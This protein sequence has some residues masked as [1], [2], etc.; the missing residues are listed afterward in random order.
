MVSRVVF[1]QVC[2]V[3]LIAAACLPAFAG[4]KVV[5]EPSAN[6]P[7]GVTIYRLDNGL[8]V[9]LTEDHQQPRFYAEIVVRAG[10]K[11][12]P[13]ETTGLAHYLEHLLFKG[14]EKIG[15]LDYAKEK[16]SLDRITELYEQH[17]KEQDP[18]KR[19]AIYAEINAESKKA[20]EF[21]IPNEF[22][23]LYKAMGGSAV[24]AHT[25]NEETVYK[26]E[27][28]SNR[29]KQWA[30]IESERFKDPVFR[31]FQPELEIVYE[32][33][34]RSM[35]NKDRII[36]EAVNAALYK[37][38]P[39]GQQTTLGSVEHLKKPSLVNIEN[40]YRT[41]YVPNNM[42]ICISGDIDKTA[43][44]KL[45]DE[46]FSVWEPKK[47]PKAGKWREKPLH[48]AE[49]VT[50][51]YPGEEYVLLAFRTAAQGKR[52]ADALRLLDMVLSNSVAGLIDLNLVQKQVVRGAGSYPIMNNDYGAQ[53]LYGIPKE[54]QSLEEVEK[55]LLA[56]IETIKKGE[57]EDWIIPAIINDFKKMRKG[58]L[59]DGE[60]RVAFM[61]DAYIG[62]E[63]WDH[64]VLQT[65]R[66]AKLTKADVVRVARKYFGNN[67]VAGYRKDGQHE[68]PKIEKPQI[69]KIAIDPRRESE[70]ARN[71]MAMPVPPLEPVFL[72]PAKDYAITD[73]PAGVRFY[74]VHNPVNDLF[75]LSFSV[76]FG[77]DHDNKLAA[78]AQL[79]DK[80]GT[81]SMSPEDLRKEWYKLGT[82][83]SVGTG[84]SESSFSIA[85]LDENLEPS[86]ALMMDVMSKPA[87]DQQTLDQL[88]EIILARRE[89]AK[90]DPGTI[91]SSLVQYNRFGKDSSFLRML[92]GDGVKALTVEEL[93][94][95]TKGLLTY[96]RT[97][98]Y[99]GSLPQDKVI[100]LIRKH[101]PVSGAL[102][103]PPP[104]RV[105]RLREPQATEIYFYNKETAQ[106]QVQIDF[107]GETYNEAHVPASI[108]FNTYFAG[109]M[110]GVV[111]QELREA[112]ALAYAVGA[113]YVTGP[114]KG[115]EN[116]MVGGMGTQADKTPEAVDGFVRLLDDMPVAEERFA[117][118][119]ESL[120]NSFTSSRIGFREVLGSVR[121]WE[122]LDLPVD[123]RRGRYEQA[124]SASLATVVDFYKAQIAGRPKLISVVGDKSKIDMNKLAAIG[125]ITEIHEDDIFVK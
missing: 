89:D 70:F 83:F 55:L 78:A 84:D 32:E 80:S 44:M 23:R 106:S 4:F 6:D 14:T 24:N 116:Y 112:R 120:L 74:Y 13:A 29:L 111:F 49:R 92:P 76:D 113:R 121:S 63:D 30:A 108:L 15:T 110:A 22:D 53:Y 79:L 69:D 88:K 93:Q 34:N 40:F 109:G 5:H 124:Q 97:V 45:I 66:M 107:A 42:A 73:D 102:Q 16:A 48:G 3:V 103:D 62:Y 21:A 114:R 25:S 91:T 19:K 122:R 61:R 77:T 59:E 81:T 68:V 11:N 54:G 82:S 39:Y 52:D 100:E 9:Y 26:V 41:Y 99:V 96:K 47:L 37:V 85:G 94:A 87:V 104:Y 10:S 51:Q 86:L 119:K 35:D 117:V 8:T 38:H 28:P 101:A 95:L 90:K 115:D 57:I 67:Y 17:F 27:L 18:E 36:T 56:Q 7:M 33:K 64:A 31:L 72:D 2:L 65:E 12:D 98:F 60:Q 105:K 118:T 46:S 20:A 58:G 71:I 123:P 125:K 43:T 75:T 1:R 50:V